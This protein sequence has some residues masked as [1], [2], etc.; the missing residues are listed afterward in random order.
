MNARRA[1]ACASALL[2]SACAGDGE[3][4]DENGRPLTEGGT[5]PPLLPQL[6]SIQSEVFTPICTTCHAGASAPLGL[7]LEEGVSFAMLVNVQSVQAP[8]LARVTPGDPD[9]SYL[10]HKIEGTAAV[11][12][13]MPLN[14]PPL[15]AET[16]AVIRQWITDGAPQGVGATSEKPAQLTAAWPPAGAT[17]AQMPREIVISADTELDASL[18]AAGTVSLRRSGGD[19]SFSDQNEHDVPVS[20]EL[21]SLQPTVVAFRASAVELPGDTFELRIS[22]GDPLALADRSARPIDGDGDGR[23]GGDFVVRFTVEGAK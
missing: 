3:G 7:R 2:L 4:L 15:P 5:E 6:S 12:G 20:V 1:I 21:R 8:S 19:A 11:G 13:R 17:L 14:G 10:I 9:A 23:P 16:I 18:F 22:G